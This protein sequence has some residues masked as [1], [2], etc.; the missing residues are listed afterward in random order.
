MMAR[1]LAASA[2]AVV[3]V[4]ALSCATS[5]R[6]AVGSPSASERPR[7]AIELWRTGDDGYTIF[8]GE[9]LEVALGESAVFSLVKVHSPTAMRLS[10]DSNL[11][12]LGEGENSKT[13]YVVVLQTADETSLGAMRGTCRRSEFA[14]CAHRVVAQAEQLLVA[15]RARYP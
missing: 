10:L 11:D 4:S 5:P 12:V 1:R 9:A 8:F 3:A 6:P 13:A 14:K 15:R 2:V 7:T